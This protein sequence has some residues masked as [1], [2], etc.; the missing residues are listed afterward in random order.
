M[1]FKPVLHQP[2]DVGCNSYAGWADRSTRRTANERGSPW[3]DQAT[4]DV[5]AQQRFSDHKE[6]VPRKPTELNDPTPTKGYRLGYASSHGSAQPQTRRRTAI[7]RTVALLGQPKASA[8]A[9]WRKCCTSPRFKRINVGESKV[10][11]IQQPGSPGT[12]GRLGLATGSRW[13]VVEGGVGKTT[14]TATLGA[15]FASLRGDR[16]VAVDANPDRG[17]AETR[18]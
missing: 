6:S 9:G 14:V 3:S 18:R 11:H 17:H 12:S 16:V 2:G 1:V 15:T 10:K 7:C 5:R 13:L 8:V 4:G